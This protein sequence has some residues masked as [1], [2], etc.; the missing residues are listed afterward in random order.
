MSSK[1]A[2]ELQRKAANVDGSDSEIKKQKEHE[3]LTLV[4]KQAIDNLGL[5]EDEIVGKEL[6]Y[7]SLEFLLNITR[8]MEYSHIPCEG[9]HWIV[10]FMCTDPENTLMQSICIGILRNFLRYQPEKMRHQIYKCGFENV[11]HAM[12]FAIGSDHACCD[13]RRLQSRGCEF[14]Q[15]F[16]MDNIDCL[17][18]LDSWQILTAVIN[19]AE[20]YFDNPRVVNAVL[21]VFEN[22]GEYDPQHWC[23]IGLIR[24]IDVTVKMLG[25]KKEENSDVLKVAQPTVEQFRRILELWEHWTTFSWNQDHMRNT[26]VISKI[27]ELLVVHM[28][29][30]AEFRYTL[31]YPTLRAISH[32][33]AE[34]EEVIRKMAENPRYKPFVQEYQSLHS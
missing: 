13:E 20:S 8:D 28:D 7:S 33:N 29:I 18:P 2:L 14:F 16:T 1:R 15:Y 32:D 3:S 25:V 21:S 30:D 12:T 5:D 19:A 4:V 31:V 6:H 34:N 17:S 27:F 23:M 22:L 24:G 26:G 9:L 10:E 11:L